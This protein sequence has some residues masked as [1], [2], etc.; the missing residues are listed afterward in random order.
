MT[1]IIGISGATRDY[2]QWM[3]DQIDVDERDL[4]AKH[5]AMA[6]NSFSF[7]RATFYRW[8]QQFPMVCPHLI[9]APQVIAIGDIHIENYGLWRDA[10]GRLVWGVN[11]FD[12]ATPAVYLNDLVRL[13]TSAI[14]SPRPPTP[15]VAAHQVLVGYR[16]ALEHGEP[17]VI[18]ERHKMI[19]DIARRQ[20]TN[21]QLFW[22]K[23]AR[24]EV[25]DNLDAEGVEVLRSSLPPDVDGV[26]V[27]R[28][29]AGMGSLGRPRAVAVG[30]LNGALIAR[31]V[32]RMLPSSS[33]WAQGTDRPSCYAQ[34]L[35]QAVRS[36]DPFLSI[37]PRWVVRRLS[38]DNCKLELGALGKASQRIALLRRMGAEL[39]NAHG[40][41]RVATEVVDHVQT[42]TTDHLAEA[43]EAMR[44][45]VLADY[46]Q[47]RT[48]SRSM[49]T[50]AAGARATAR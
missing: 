13:V 6:T 37:H 19:N 11:D 46:Q 4:I 45:A 48:D 40:G 7:L 32:K 47:F 49:L 50:R 35:Q 22:K 20:M 1:S 2:E 14:M 28:R 23:L 21:P 30:N 27:S 25:G 24:P 17:F 36:K 41:N 33:N 29:V 12:E 9:D 31:E 39:A 44:R 16:R 43:A 8:A 38:P 15:T 3:R 10:E 26:A 42:L 5:Q 18:A 34:I